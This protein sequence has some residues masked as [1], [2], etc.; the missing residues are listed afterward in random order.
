LGA[1]FILRSEIRD[2]WLLATGNS[3]ALIIRVDSYR[4][5]VRSKIRGFRIG[6][7]PAILPIKRSNLRQIIGIQ[8]EI[9]YFEIFADARRGY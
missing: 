2:Q 7:N 8:R 6:T 3:E 5:A 1:A 4:F 9:E